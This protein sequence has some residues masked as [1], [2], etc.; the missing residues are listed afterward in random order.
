MA[1]SGTT[2]IRSARVDN[3]FA[4]RELTDTLA[5]VR[6]RY[7]TDLS[8]FFEHTREIARAEK[9]EPS[10]PRTPSDDSIPR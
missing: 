8:T 3:P 6:E 10:L 5:K 1:G 2:M 9:A 4:E 7:G